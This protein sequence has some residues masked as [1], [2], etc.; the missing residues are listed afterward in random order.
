MTRT[1]LITGAT[2]GIGRAIATALAPT[3]HV[4]LVG[5]R[6]GGLDALAKKLSSASVCVADLGDMAQIA[7]LASGIPTL[8][9]LVHSAGVLHMGTTEEL[10]PEQWWESLE[11]NVLA[12]VQLTRML[13]PALRR[14]RGQVLFINSG[15]GHRTMP[16][17]G[18]YS[19]SKFALRAFADTLRQEE[20]PHGIRVTSIHPGRVATPMQEQLRAWEGQPYD[21]EAW[22]RPEQVADA[23]L[24]IVNL[25]RNADITTL[26]ITPATRR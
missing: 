9:V 20:A 12:P 13:L 19:A 16:G 14:A 22:I 5:R 24:T 2:G 26:D 6:S 7:E 11:V 10:T 18:A 3:H 1:A 17:S 8:D 25:D 23:A 15:L 4:H 21:G